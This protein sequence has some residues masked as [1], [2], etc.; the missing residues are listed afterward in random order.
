[1][2]RHFKSWDQIL[3]DIRQGFIAA[4][5]DDLNISEALASIFKMIKQANRLIQDHKL[6]STDAEKIVDAFRQIDSVLHIFDFGDK[7]ADPRIQELIEERNQARREKN[8]AR[9]DEIRET[10]R[11]L[12]ITVQDQKTGKSP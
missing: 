8:W 1:M 9:A 2:G 4:M 10:L 7:M 11:S 3:Y 6:N 5:D 12:G